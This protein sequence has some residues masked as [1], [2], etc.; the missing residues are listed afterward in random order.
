[1]VLERIFEECFYQLCVHLSSW[2]H[3]V[4]KYRYIIKIYWEKYQPFYNVIAPLKTPRLRQRH[5]VAPHLCRLYYSTTQPAPTSKVH[6]QNCSV[7]TDA[8]FR[9]LSL[10]AEWDRRWWC[11]PFDVPS[12]KKKSQSTEGRNNSISIVVSNAQRDRDTSVIK[13]LLCRYS[14]CAFP[15]ARFVMARCLVANAVD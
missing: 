6:P 15:L 4:Y 11:M 9:N 10:L 8:S 12:T 2:K 7:I 5:I 3:Y 13:C 1:M 14:N